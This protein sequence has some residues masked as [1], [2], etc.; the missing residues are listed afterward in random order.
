MNIEKNIPISTYKYSYNFFVEFMQQAEINDSLLLDVESKQEVNRCRVN[1]D[2]ATQGTNKKFSF[3]R[4][5]TGYRV[6]RI[7]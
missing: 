2:R 4:Q 3:R 6:W 7:K 1:L 5:Q